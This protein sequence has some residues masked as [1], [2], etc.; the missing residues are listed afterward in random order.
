VF[1]VV[2]S[3]GRADMDGKNMN[4]CV[5][6]SMLIKPR[7]LIR[8]GNSTAVTLP[9]EWLTSQNLKI[10]DKVEL[11]EAGQAL[12]IQPIKKEKKDD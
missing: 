12:C 9:S 3:N 4:R 5:N 11:S 1:T 7:T 8:V 2:S 10:G 6:S